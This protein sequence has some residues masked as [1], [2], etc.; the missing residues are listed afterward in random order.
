MN[1]ISLLVLNIQTVDTF[2]DILLLPA[3]VGG[4]GA[5]VS[6][7]WSSVLL[8]AQQDQ[9]GNNRDMNLSLTAVSV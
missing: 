3:C 8:L 9:R 2:L 5:A 6:H 7:L 4:R 1:P